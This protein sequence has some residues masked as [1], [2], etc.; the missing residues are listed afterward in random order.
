MKIFKKNHYPAYLEDD[1]SVGKQA[2]IF[3]W[4][5]FKVVVISLAIII[6]VRYYLIKPFYV[7]GASMEP[8]FYDHEYLIINELS[9]HLG[10]PVRGDAVVFKYPMDPTQYFIKRVIGL[11]GETVKIAD[12]EVT[13]IN[14]ANPQGV[15]LDE[16]YLDSTAKTI[17]DIEVTLGPDEY[18]LLGDNRLASLDSR[19]FGPV[20]ED[21]IVG[22]T[23]FRGWPISRAGLITNNLE[24]NL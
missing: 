11:P 16:R 9:Y 13:I 20:K 8:T 21:F 12:G 4:E 3:V 5:I 15:T 7:K 19:V 17:G 14:S 6:P 24:Y 10:S 23:L 1:L 2:A 18:Y 22:K